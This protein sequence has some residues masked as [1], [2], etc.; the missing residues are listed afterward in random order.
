[1]RLSHNYVLYKLSLHLLAATIHAHHPENKTDEEEE[2]Q[3]LALLA[4]MPGLLDFRL[5]A[6]GLLRDISSWV[7]KGF[8]KQSRFAKVIEAEKAAGGFFQVAE[9]EEEK[10]KGVMDNRMVDEMWKD[11]KKL[12]GV[13]LGLCDDI[14]VKCN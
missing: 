12:V 5:I 7:G 1:M 9:E 13:T 10:E 2:E 3:A 8:G 6:V 14:K 4:K 11:L